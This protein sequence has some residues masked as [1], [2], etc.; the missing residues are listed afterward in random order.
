MRHGFLNID[1]TEKGSKLSG[2]FYDNEQGN[3]IDHFTI[4]KKTKNGHK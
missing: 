1:L 2:T 4:K 3:A